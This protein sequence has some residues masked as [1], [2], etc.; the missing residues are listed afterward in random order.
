LISTHTPPPGLPGHQ[1]LLGKDCSDRCGL[2][3]LG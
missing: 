1:L 3:A 2:S